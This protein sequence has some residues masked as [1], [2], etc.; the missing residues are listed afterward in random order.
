M[1]G[2]RSGRSFQL[3]GRVRVKVARVD[4]ETTKIDFTLAEEPGQAAAA[5]GL[6]RAARAHRSRRQAAA[7]ALGPR[8]PM[9]ATAPEAARG[10]APSPWR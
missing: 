9:P 6:R 2:E 10:A 7:A 1:I 5:A 3:A 4:L 8:T